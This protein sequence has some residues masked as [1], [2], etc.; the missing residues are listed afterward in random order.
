MSGVRGVGV[1]NT[2]NADV[3]TD[4]ASARVGMIKQIVKRQSSNFIVS[5]N[6]YWGKVNARDAHSSDYIL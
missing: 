4:W 1:D 2:G 5:S 3:D 6:S